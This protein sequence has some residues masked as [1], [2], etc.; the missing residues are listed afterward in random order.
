MAENAVASRLS[1]TKQLTITRLPEGQQSFLKQDADGEVQ[2]FNAPL[3]APEG[4]LMFDVNN[5]LRI[6]GEVTSGG[7]P[8]TT[9]QGA[10]QW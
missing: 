10:T 2:I 3:L 1:S 8:T 9:R 7:T 5:Q 6:A 4:G